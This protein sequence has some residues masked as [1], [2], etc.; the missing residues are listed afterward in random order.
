MSERISEAKLREIE[1]RGVA[2]IPGAPM[3]PSAIVREDYRSLTAAVRRLRG[4]IVR[5]ASED[6]RGYCATCVHETTSDQHRPGCPWPEMLAEAEAS[7][8]EN[9]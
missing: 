9:A 8:A 2:V 6:F 4:L 1:A 3:P 7:R 5:S